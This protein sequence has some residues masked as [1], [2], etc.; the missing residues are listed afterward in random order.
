MKHGNSYYLQLTR[1]I[2]S[3]KYSSLSVNAKW[4][5]VVLNELE[6]KYTSQRQEFFFRTNDELAKDCGLSMATFKRAK[7][8][9]LDTDLIH[10]WQAHFVSPETGKKSEKHITCYRILK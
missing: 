7:Q 2:F 4:L 10:T 5:F 1:E 6:Q 3:D 8:E 9:L